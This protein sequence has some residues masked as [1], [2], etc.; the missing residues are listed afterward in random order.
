MATGGGNINTQAL[1]QGVMRTPT[2]QD[3]RLTALDQ[4]LRKEDGLVVSHPFKNGLLSHETDPRGTTWLL[5]VTPS[6]N[7]RALHR[8]K[9]SE[10]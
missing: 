6:R 4:L 2:H 3:T 8:Q 1:E 5:G 10:V 9:V 7:R